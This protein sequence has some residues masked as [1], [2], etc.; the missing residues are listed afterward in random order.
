MSEV[1]VANTSEEII[2]PR[3]R[4]IR[5]YACGGTG[6]NLLRSHR[7]D[8]VLKQD[9]GSAE[10]LY[11]YIDTSFANLHNV[12][13]RETFT[14]KGLDGSGSDR[15]KNAAAIKAVMP[16]ILLQHPPGDL[17]VFIFSASGGSGSVAGPLLWEELQSKN[18]T[19]MAI[20]IGS[21]ETLKRTTNVSGTITGLE[22]AVKRTGRPFVMYYSEND[23]AKSMVDNNIMPKFVLSSLGLLGSGRNQA[24]DGADLQNL[25]D[26]HT[27]SH[28]KPGLAMLDVF[29]KPEDVKRASSRPI[30]YVA[31]L[32][33]EDQVAPAIEADYDK[34]GYLP[35][36]A[37]SKNNFFFIVSVD[38]L[39]AKFDKLKERK[40]EVGMKKRTGQAATTLSSEDTVADDT[41]LV[42][43]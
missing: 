9:D 28:N 10:E 35:A 32:S 15:P 29:T 27:V 36:D 42:F 23:P 18:K 31:L 26:Y 6:I 19:C 22:T 20:V 40:E 11:T 1:Q 17:N 41:G 21:H 13:A 30:A 5:Y 12:V 37:G 25:F 38:Q 24:L 16:Q 43:D 33:G 3:T 4:T 39:T 8:I 7:G 34:T 14:L 2:K